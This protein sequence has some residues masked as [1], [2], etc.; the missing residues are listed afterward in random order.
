M[1][2]DKYTG[3]IDF[4][5]LKQILKKLTAVGSIFEIVNNFSRLIILDQLFRTDV[6]PSEASM[7]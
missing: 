7:L 2:I 5:N 6:D 1:Y 4:N 3:K